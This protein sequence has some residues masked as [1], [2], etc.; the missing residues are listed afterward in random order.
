L[1]ERQRK[2]RLPPVR[3]NRST[4]RSRTS[5]PQVCTYFGQCVVPPHAEPSDIHGLATGGG[6]LRC[7]APSFPLAGAFPLPTLIASINGP[8]VT[9]LDFAQRINT[10]A[11]VAAFIFVGAV[12]FGMF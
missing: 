11:I 9:Q 1:R 8:G 7:N 3:R 5:L 4:A 6:Q 12:L 10:V 2:S